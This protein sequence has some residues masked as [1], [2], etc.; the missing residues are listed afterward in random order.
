MT[1]QIKKILWP[2]AL[3]L[4]SISTITSASD[5]ATFYDAADFGGKAVALPPG[6][7]T[8]GQLKE[9]GIADKSISSLIIT[10]GYQVV[11]YRDD[12]FQGDSMVFT[13]GI[14]GEAKNLKNDEVRDDLTARISSVRIFK[15][16]I[17][18]PATRDTD[19]ENEALDGW[20]TESMENHDAR[21]QWWRDAR[22]GCFMHWGVYSVLAGQWQNAKG[23]YSE[24]VMRWGKIPLDVYKKM[25]VEKFN[26]VDFNADEWIKLLKQ[27]GMKYLIITAK[28]HDGFAVYRSDA[29]YYDLDLTPFKRDPMMELREACTRHGLKFGF[30]YSQ[31]FDWEH[32]DGAGNDWDYRNPAGDKNLWGGRDWYNQH[33]ELLARVSKYYTD[34]KATPQLLE[35]IKKYH[36]DI[37]WGDTDGKLPL[38]EKLKMLKAIRAIDNNIVINGRF[39][40]GGKTKNFGD[41]ANTSDRPAELTSHEGDW[42]AIPTTNESYGYK[43]DD[44][45]YKAISYFVRLLAKAAARGGNVLLNVGPRPDGKIDE[46]DAAIL[47]AIG[48]WMK[49]NGQCIYGS[50]KTPLDVQAW[51]ESS[52]KGNMLFLHVFEWPKDGKLLLGGLKSD[53]AK[54]Y[55][56]ADADKKLLK[57]SRVN[58]NDLMIEVPFDAPDDSDSVVV[59]E[60]NGDIATHPGRLLSDKLDNVL[61]AFDADKHSK[62]RYGDGKAGK[63]Y[64]EGWNSTSQKVKWKIR[65]N[66]KASYQ[67]S[68]KYM[69]DAKDETDAGKYQI[70]IGNQKFEKTVVPTGTGK[71]AKA[72]LGAVT[73]EAGEYDLTI[74]PLEIKGA[75]LMKLHNVSLTPLNSP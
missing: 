72:D 33:P 71:S 34:Q 5:V 7:Y 21:I 26:P 29:Y 51:G 44:K 69:T 55:L 43:K 32:P 24:H 61:R 46:P 37:L 59:L 20:W 57:T 38:S 6:D 41:Y 11:V 62:L 74:T 19:A 28:H 10:D 14:N 58:V 45:S 31:A 70:T 27:A 13:G 17:Q 18:D 47:T 52:R 25:A 39:C 68:V 63:D 66:E 3:V 60:V 12:N 2:A 40:R 64:I 22:F 54:A 50:Q 65:S 15:P 8:A 35:L 23:T 67:L 42:E 56:L 73:I 36:P 30:Y 53:A 16:V 48:K 49:V 1:N 9:K 4:F 75:E